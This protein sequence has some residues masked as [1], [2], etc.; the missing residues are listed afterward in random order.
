[1][2]YNERGNG[3]WMVVNRAGHTYYCFRKFIMK[4]AKSFMAKQKKKY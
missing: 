4:N 3:S 1:M 2:G